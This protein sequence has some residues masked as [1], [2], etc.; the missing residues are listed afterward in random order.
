MTSTAALGATSPGFRFRDASVE[1]AGT[2]GADAAAKLVATTGLTA[3][4]LVATTGLTGVAVVG[5]T[6]AVGFGAT[7]EGCMLETGAA[8]GA[9]PLFFGTLSYN[10][11]MS[12]TFIAVLP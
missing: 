4:K 7:R 10:K 8:D 9:L 5:V 1:T 6:G 3:A 11:Q 12:V 2:T